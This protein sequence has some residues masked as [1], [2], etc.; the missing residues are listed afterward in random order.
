MNILVVVKST[1]GGVHVEIIHGLVLVDLVFIGNTARLVSACG[2]QPYFMSEKY[3]NQQR[4][5]DK[6]SKKES[7]NYFLKNTHL[8]HERAF[9]SMSDIKV[10]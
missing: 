6:Y 2:L 5:N 9:C 10:S 8:F 3:K 1:R 4:K 7:N